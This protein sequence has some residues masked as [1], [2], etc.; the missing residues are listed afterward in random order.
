MVKGFV[1]DKRVWGHYEGNWQHIKDA[2][3]NG[4]AFGAA[5]LA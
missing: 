5:S 2:Y 1:T 3:V 4:S